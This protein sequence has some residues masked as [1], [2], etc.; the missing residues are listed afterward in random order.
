[1]RQSHEILRGRQLSAVDEFS[2]RR[3]RDVFYEAL[4]AGDRCDAVG[5]EINA[6]HDGAGL[7]ERHRERQADVPEADHA[8]RRSGDEPLLKHFPVRGHLLASRVTI[9][10]TNAKLETPSIIVA[11]SSPTRSRLAADAQLV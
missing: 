11:T 10:I 9:I 4:P 1:G 3:A 2:E 6:E 8:N 7:S 5:I